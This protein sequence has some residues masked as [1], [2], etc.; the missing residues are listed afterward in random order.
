M[1]LFYPLLGSGKSKVRKR[2]G[3]RDR[4]NHPS[5]E[6]N[7]SSPGFRFADRVRGKL[8]WTT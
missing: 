3:K 8:T 6:R 2:A 1:K 7:C 5:S 4:D